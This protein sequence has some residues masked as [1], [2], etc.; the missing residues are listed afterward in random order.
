[1]MNLKKPLT[2]HQTNTQQKQAE[3]RG[4]FTY[5]EIISQPEAWIEAI[6]VLKLNASALS[7]FWNKEELGQ[8]IFTGCGSTYYL[9][10][11]AAAL[12][13]EMTGR[14]TRGLPASELWLSPEAN[15]VRGGKALLIAVSRSGETSETLAACEQFRA[16]QRGKIITL[17]CK[18]G[19]PLTYLGDLNLVF[20]SGMERSIAQTRAFSTL[21][22]A[23][24]AI[25]AIWAEL[26]DPFDPMVKLASVARKILNEYQA[27]AA[28]YGKN[29]G[30]DRIY[31]LGSGSRLGLACELSL[32]MKEMSLTHS[33][34]F[35]FMEFRHG[36]KAMINP[37]TLVV[38]LVSE[39]NASHELAVVDD[40]KQLGGEVITIGEDNTD[41]QF[42]SLLKEVYR[43]VLYLPFGQMLAYQRS[44]AKGLDPDRPEN[45]DAVVKL[46]H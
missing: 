12:F 1:M 33:E 17:V 25:S 14:V 27:R 42:N 28:G 31:F 19:S 11:S 38:G 29:L 32:K 26:P 9:S 43:N 45:L 8:V 22:L 44:I 30:Y 46:S 4:K 6:E 34:A 16:N 7:D 39:A 2:D 23:T 5:E 21:Y 13:Q 10:R 15:C 40:V 20:P 37:Q 36:P 18:T 3:E 24:L 35:H 41:I